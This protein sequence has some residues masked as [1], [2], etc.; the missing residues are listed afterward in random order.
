LVA[1]WFPVRTRGRAFAFHQTAYTLG[2]V[3]VP[4]IAVPLAQALGSWRWS[5]MIIAFFGLPVLAAIDRFVI[6][7]PERDPKVTQ[8]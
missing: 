5:F 4:F 7:R 1:T 2:P 3:I 6:D 8:E